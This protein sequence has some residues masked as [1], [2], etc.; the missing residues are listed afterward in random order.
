MKGNQGQPVA[1][2]ATDVFYRDR[3]EA[4]AGIA[5]NIALVASFAVALMVV[6]ILKRIVLGK[7][8]SVRLKML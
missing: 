5:N 8:K 1:W 4:I 2:Q 3:K 7:A 6:W